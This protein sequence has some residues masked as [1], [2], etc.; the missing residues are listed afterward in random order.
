MHGHEKKAFRAQTGCPF[1]AARFLRFR[2][3]LMLSSMSEMRS[4]SRSGGGSL[5]QSSRFS[6]SGRGTALSSK[7]VSS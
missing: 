4:M 2:A 3:W 7:G 6:P 5:L 1:A